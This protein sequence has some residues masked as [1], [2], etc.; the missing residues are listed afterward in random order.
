MEPITDKRVNIPF[1]LLTNGGGVP[2]DLKAVEM[3]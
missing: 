3:N 2:E 1:T